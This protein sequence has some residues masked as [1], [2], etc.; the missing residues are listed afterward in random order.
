[1][2]NYLVVDGVK[3]GEH[4]AVDAGLLPRWQVGRQRFVEPATASGGKKCARAEAAKGEGRKKKKK[5][6][7]ETPTKR[8]RR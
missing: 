4:D 1:M 7:Y 8:R 6:S 5:N 3:L 2:L